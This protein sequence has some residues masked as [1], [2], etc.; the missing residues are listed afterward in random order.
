MKITR[1]G[2]KISRDSLPPGGQA[3]QGGKINCYTGSIFLHFMDVNPRLSGVVF[4]LNQRCMLI[5]FD[6]GSVSLYIMD[7]YPHL[8]GFVI[9]FYIK[10]ICKWLLILEMSIYTLCMY[11]LKLFAY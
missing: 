7:V 6:A 8:S 5:A 11:H 9:L 1:V 10:S 4:F 2:G 3:V